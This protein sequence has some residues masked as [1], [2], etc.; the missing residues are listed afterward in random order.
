MGLGIPA[1]VLFGIPAH[2]DPV[3]YENF[4][5]DGIVQQAIRAIKTAVPDLLVITDVCLCEYTDHGHCGLARR[6]R[7]MC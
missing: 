3:G 2:K 5:D 7:A 4:A 6:A 1:V